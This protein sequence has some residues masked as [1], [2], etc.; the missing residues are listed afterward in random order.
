[1]YEIYLNNFKHQE[2]LVMWGTGVVHTEFWWEDLL[3]KDHLKDIGIDGRII[4][5]WILRNC[6]GTHGLD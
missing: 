3:E 1:V 2:K 4:L 6:V 5:K